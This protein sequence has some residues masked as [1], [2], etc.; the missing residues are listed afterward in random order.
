[1][2]FRK[3][4]LGYLNSLFKR[5]DAF[6][7]RRRPVPCPDAGQV[8]A[9]NG[10]APP[11]VPQKNGVIEPG[12]E[13]KE[14]EQKSPGSVEDDRQRPFALSRSTRISVAAASTTTVDLTNT[15]PL[16][17]EPHKLK[18]SG[19]C[20][21]IFKGAGPSTNSATRAPRKRAVLIGICYGTEKNKFW[22]KLPTASKDV[23]KVKELLEQKG[24]TEFRILS[25]PDEPRPNDY[26]DPTRDEIIGAL[27]WLVE[28]VQADDR[29]FLLYSGHGDQVKTKDYSESD[30]RDEAIVPLNCDG[31]YVTDNELHTILVE[32]VRRT[33][34]SQL[35]A[36]FDC[37]HSGTM[38]DIFHECTVEPSSPHTD[39][40]GNVSH[41][42][43]FP[44]RRPISMD[45]KSADGLWKGEAIFG[46]LPKTV[47]DSAIKTRLR[48]QSI[49]VPCPDKYVANVVP[50]NQIKIKDNNRPPTV[51]ISAKRRSTHSS[52]QSKERKQTG[53]SIQH[54]SAHQSTSD[55]HPPSRGLVE[56]PE[57]VAYDEHPAS[58][59]CSL[60][61]SHETK[62]RL[63]KAFT[64]SHFNYGPKAPTGRVFAIAACKDNQNVF[65]TDDEG[66][67]LSSGFVDYM[68]KTREEDSTVP[69][70]V[71]YLWNRFKD[72][73]G[74]MHASCKPNP[75][76]NGTCK[77]KDCTPETAKASSGCGWHRCGM[78][79]DPPV[80][81]VT[82]LTD[83]NNK[84]NI[85]L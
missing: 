51:L 82:S 61:F 65:D 2:K 34:G 33:P 58:Q 32:P 6:V 5:L 81:F 13:E 46:E 49:I 77:R 3:P 42:A 80:P 73:T 68:S 62:M 85:W 84:T 19:V 75:C 57:P 36:L 24:Y 38:L 83:M 11:D 8:S 50:K 16:H 72:Y 43:P 23:E 76:K 41:R 27:Q 63:L 31:N 30:G 79:V 22:C 39:R 15:A 35:I 7:R 53:D 1:M 9:V 71:H 66:G 47:K 78:P 52:Q 45:C 59:R 60:D 48:L 4:R 70:L 69:N 10:P 37:C 56:S 25:D 18:R 12:V 54:S 64:F 28:D 55:S 21:R 44:L 26:R 20:S 29:L 67:L 14:P 74:Q 40:S 17:S